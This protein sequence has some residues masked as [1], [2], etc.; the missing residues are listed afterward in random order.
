MI[1]VEVASNSPKHREESRLESRLASVV[2]ARQED[3]FSAR[4]SRFAMMGIYR[5]KKGGLRRSNMS[6]NWIKVADEALQQ[7]K[8]QNKP[9]LVDFSAA[10]A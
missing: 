5:S 10:P 4:L 7:A 2:A 3:F 6:V 9:L 1:K 8:D